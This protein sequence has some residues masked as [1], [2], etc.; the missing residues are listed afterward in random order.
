MG[1]TLQGTGTMCFRAIPILTII[2]V[3][4]LSNGVSA[5]TLTAGKFETVLAPTQITDA[6]KFTIT[7]SG[8]VTA[9]LQG[10]KFSVSG[11]FSGLASPATDAHVMMGIGI[12]IPGSPAFDLSVST[13]TSGTVSGS[14]TLSQPQV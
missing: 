14:F 4:S 10:N 8:A 3:A 1:T 2:G 13:E 9:T 12:G 11:S 6:T 7:G 5:A